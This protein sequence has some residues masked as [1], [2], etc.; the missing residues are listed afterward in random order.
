MEIFERFKELNSKVFFDDFE[1]EFQ[2]SSL[3]A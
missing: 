3:V 1:M 2:A